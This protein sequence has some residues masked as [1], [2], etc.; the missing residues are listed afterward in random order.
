[1]LKRERANRGMSCGKNFQEINKSNAAMYSPRFH[2][3]NR[4]KLAVQGV[5]RQQGAISQ[6]DKINHALEE[7]SQQRQQEELH[8]QERIDKILELRRNKRLFT[9]RHKRWF[10]LIEL[11]KFSTKIN[12]DYTH[13]KEILEMF[14]KEDHA[15]RLM[16][17]WFLRKRTMRRRGI[18][19]YKRLIMVKTGLKAFARFVQTIF[20]KNIFSSPS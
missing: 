2:H 17:A 20:Q 10:T 11:V 12:S 8:R 16:Q 6:R 14:R 7:K 3:E 4:I 18:N 5:K 1:M 15:A 19:F 9:E 13:R